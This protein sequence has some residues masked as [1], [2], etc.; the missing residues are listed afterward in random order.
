[1]RLNEKNRESMQLTVLIFRKSVRCPL[2]FLFVH[3]SLA[4]YLLT[5]LS[6]LLSTISR[7]AFVTLF[8]SHFSSVHF[9]FSFILLSLVFVSLETHIRTL[10]VRRMG[11]FLCPCFRYCCRLRCHSLSLP[12]YLVPIPSTICAWLHWA[13]KIKWSEKKKQELLVIIASNC[14]LHWLQYPLLAYGTEW[15]GLDGLASHKTNIF[16]IPFEY[17]AALI[18]SVQGN[19]EDGGEKGA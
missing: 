7:N 19:K 15:S 10:S 18:S 3:F 13:N 6:T 17:W 4:L 11:N 1:M 5:F 16:I 8:F 9:C 12:W 2:E 14:I